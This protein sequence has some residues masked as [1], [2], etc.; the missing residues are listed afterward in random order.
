MS[1]ASRPSA[2]SPSTS[3]STALPARGGGSPAHHSDPSAG[4]S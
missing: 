4:G 2:T 1:A 3:G